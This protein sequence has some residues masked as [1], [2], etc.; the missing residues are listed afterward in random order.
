ME[1]KEKKS[2]GFGCHTP[3]S[4]PFGIPIIILLHFTDNNNMATLGTFKEETMWRLN[5]FAKKK[6]H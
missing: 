3:L 1:I 2:K 4:E 5:E 6:R